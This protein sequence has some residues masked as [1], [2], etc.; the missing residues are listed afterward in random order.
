MNDFDDFDTTL[1]DMAMLLNRNLEH[2]P[3]RERV[4]ARRLLEEFDRVR[5]LPVNLNR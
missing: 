5:P 4:E 3:E 1:Y 2:L